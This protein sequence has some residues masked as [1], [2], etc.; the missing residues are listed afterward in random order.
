MSTRGFWELH[1][2]SDN[3]LDGGLRSLLSQS[4]GVEARIVAHLAEMDAR[5]THS[6]AG[7]SLFAYCLGQLGLSEMEAFYR[8]TAARLARKFPMIFELLE[9]GRIHLTG[10]CLLRR[11]LTPSNHRELLELASGNSKRQI[12]RMLA[13][14]FPRADVPDRLQKIEPLSADRYRLELT[15]SELMKQKLE[16][17]LDLTAHS[18]PERHLEPLLERALDLLIERVQGRR[19]GAPAVPRRRASTAAEALREHAETRRVE[20]P[21]AQSSRSQAESVRAESPGES[22]HVRAG[23]PQAEPSHVESSYDK[24]S[25]S[26]S[27]QA[28]SS[29]AE[30]AIQRIPTT[31][32]A[33]ASA[34]SRPL[35]TESAKPAR[36]RAHIKHDAR[37]EVV[38]RDGSCCSFVAED[39]T[40]CG[41]RAF[42]QLHH[43]KA[44]ANGGSDDA[45]NLRLLCAAHNRLLAEQEFGK[46]RVERAIAQ[47]QRLFRNKQ[48]S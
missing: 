9:T 21:Q 29:Q 4:R 15:I 18:N 36:T 37:R 13:Q 43:E 39:G 46:E 25:K 41:S 28:E 3:E 44:W 27:S 7:I 32:A 30:P 33:M 17:A 22:S 1:A 31:A 40:R 38:K 24:A 34:A 2:L 42:L 16:L 19:F 12:E 35:E 11:H 47:R 6:K 14:R 8:I 26:E 48:A 23:S 10:L 5:R 45:D 20:S